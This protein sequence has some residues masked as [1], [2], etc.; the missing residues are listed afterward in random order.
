MK[1]NKIFFKPLFLSSIVALLALL[2]SIQNY[3]SG[4]KIYGEEV[5]EYTH[6]NNYVIFQ[7][8]FFHL[9]EN[10]D[11][12]ALY[13]KEQ[14]DLFKYSPTFALFMAPMAALPTDLGLC[15][16]NLLNAFVLFLA[17]WK[18]P[19]K[20]NKVKLLML[21]FLLIELINSIQ[22]A[23][24]NALMAGLIVLAFVFLER[25]K[26]ALASLVI[27]LSIFIKL[28]GVVALVLF[29]LYPNKLKAALY[30]LLW[31][32]LFAFLPL[33]LVSFDQLIF[34]YKSWFYLLGNDHS[35]SIGLSVAGWL[36]TWF[37]LEFKTGT[38][39]IGMFLFCLFVVRYKFFNELK[40]K[41]LLL[42][43]IL[44]WIVIFNHKA[45]SPTFIIA[46]SGVSIWFFS[47]K[48]NWKTITLMIFAFI[49]TVLSASD[50]F[51]RSLRDNFVT[52]YVMKA[53]P[54]ILIWFVIT[55]QILFYKSERELN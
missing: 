53:V 13:P 22:N 36:F 18:L 20:S 9:I 35:I 8:S 30:I 48:A 37:H 32:L 25:Q 31:M 38:L 16:W 54:C 39:L 40:F 34:L 47:Q 50:L 51:P 46:L 27:V 6:Y 11:L 33:L 55:W 14:F 49:F 7:Q 26:I 21:G 42:S 43:S 1:G 41:L 44:I 17:F 23:Q 28:F 3:Y 24:S 19:S 5:R 10:K 52:P 15:I 12:Y 29:L 45:E 2:I 4:P